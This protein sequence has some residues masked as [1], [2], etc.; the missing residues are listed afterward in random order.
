MYQAEYTED[1]SYML[2][3]GFETIEELE[4]YCKSEGI[5]DYRIVK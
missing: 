4:S 3:I 5:T 1:G 2:T